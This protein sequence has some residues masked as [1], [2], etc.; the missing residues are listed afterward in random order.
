MLQN[1][2]WQRVVQ[3]QLL[4][5]LFVGAARAGGGFFEHRQAKAVVQNLAQ[6]LGAAEVEGLTGAGVRLLLQRHNALAQL[7][8][9]ARQRGGVDQHAV[10]LDAVQ[11]LGAI[12]FERIDGAQFLIRLQPRPQAL[13]HL[14][15]EIAVFAGVAAGAFDVHLGKRYLL[16]AL[17]AQLGVA[18]AAPAQMALGQA[19]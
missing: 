14:E 11:H 4:Q 19:L 1:L 8:A 12:D 16:R 7:V 13:V 15:R 9:L 6:L 17:A 5:H 18:G 2:G 3:R 10:A